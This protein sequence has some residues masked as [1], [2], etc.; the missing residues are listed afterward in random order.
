MSSRRHR[1]GRRTQ[2]NEPA[3]ALA[4]TGR[5]PRRHRSRPR[6]ARPAGGLVRRRRLS[7]V[8]LEVL[9]DYFHRMPEPLLAAFYKA[10]GGQPGRVPSRDRMIQLAVRAVA[11]GSRLAA[12]LKSMHERDRQALAILIQCGGLAHADEFLRELFLSLGGHES[13]WRRVM[14]RLG[15]KGLVFASETRDDQFFYLVPHH[16]VD[17]LVDH[18]RADM[19]LPI[20]DNDE[21]RVVD[22]RPF[23]P[24]LDFSITTLATYMDQRPPRLTQRQEIYK[25][26]KEEMDQFF[27]QLWATDSELFNLHVDFLMLHG[28]VELRGDRISVNR[29]A[30]EQW[31]N[32]DSEDQRELIFAALE[33]RFPQAE[34]ILWAVAEGDGAWIPDK[35]LSALYRRWQRGEDW[36]K[37]YHQGLFVSGRTHERESFGFAPLVNTGMLE[38]GT[39]GREK[40]Y[41]LSPRARH[42]LFPPE[43][44]GFS[45]FYLTPSFEIMAPAGLAPVLLARIGELAEL[46][47]CDRANTYKVTEVTIEQAL[48]RGWR[49][50]DVLDFLRENSQIGL[51]ENVEQTLR[52]W[53]GHHGDVEFHDVVLLT[54]HRSAIRKL[55]THKRLKPFLLHRFA[56]GMYA[57]DRSRFEELRQALKGAGFHPS[58][59]LRAYP[60][61]GSSSVL[62]ER[63][64]QV[65]AELREASEDPLARA[66]AEDTAPEDLHPVPGSGIRDRKTRKGRSALPPKATPE[67][68]EQMLRE[69]I[70][71]GQN[72]ELVYVT[73]DDRHTLVQVAPERLAINR[74]GVQV[75]VARNLEKDERLTYRTAQIERIRV[76]T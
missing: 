76:M 31:L 40:F 70:T 6:R 60:A 32:L 8:E 47:G 73:R 57:V 66:Q 55:E 14:Q 27:G 23:C 16:L 3:V 11:Q 10:M 12:L 39:W 7:R 18:L 61:A 48:E 69:A 34:W 59:E 67:E 33:K 9:A 56:P 50:D 26:H 35:P 42:L 20:F 22:E 41:R 36:R 13:E 24:P 2:P 68:A 44:D 1:R 21:I 17:H 30:V 71:A 52:G 65:V 51:P 4:D 58:D 62:R 28:M 54:V 63:L 29:E 64:Q 25:V 19:V 74:E 43:D 49:R 45:Q 53:M 15:E 72:V 75:L 46:T 5:N 37:R 38:L